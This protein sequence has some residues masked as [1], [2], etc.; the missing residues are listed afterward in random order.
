M[1][2]KRMTHGKFS[3]SI[4][5]YVSFT[6]STTKTYDTTAEFI[7]GVCGKTGW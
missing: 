4:N 5:F 6:S 1:W 3:L 7:G 2:Y